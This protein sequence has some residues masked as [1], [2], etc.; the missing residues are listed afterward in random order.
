MGWI[1]EANKLG[2]YH[3]TW[4]GFRIYRNDETNLFHAV[5]KD[6]E[7]YSGR[8]NM[9]LSKIDQYTIL[10]RMEKKYGE[11][12]EWIECNQKLKSNN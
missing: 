1:K 5:N 7:S 4:E 11:K 2:E 12:F 9:C 8:L 3:S 6:G 10:K